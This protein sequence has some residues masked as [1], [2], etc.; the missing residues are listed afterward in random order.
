M[1]FKKSGRLPNNTVFNSDN[2]EIEI[3]KN[4]TYL[5]IVFRTGGSFSKTQSALS[6]QALKAI[7]QIN[8]YLHKFTSLSVQHR[9]DL[10]EK[11]ITPILNYGSQVW[12]FAHCT[13]IERVHLQC[14]KRLLGV[15]N[16]PKMTLYMESL[17]V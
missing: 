10:C 17:D 11:L 14:C 16:V 3:V 13:C 6:G 15:K 5:G 1:I 4:F 7:F 2:V 8:K 12:G 9:L